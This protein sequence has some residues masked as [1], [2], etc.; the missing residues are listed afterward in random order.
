MCQVRYRASDATCPCVLCDLRVCVVA[1]SA[2]RPCAALCSRRS[3][4]FFG[5]FLLRWSC[6]SQPSRVAGRSCGWRC[7]VRLVRDPLSL[8]GAG[9]CA[10]EKLPRPIVSSAVAPDVDVS[11][12]VLFNICTSALMRHH[13]TESFHTSSVDYCLVGLLRCIRYLR[14]CDPSPSA[15]PDAV[16]LLHF[17]FR[18]CLFSLHVPEGAASG[19]TAGASTPASSATAGPAAPGGAAPASSATD[20]TGTATPDHMSSPARSAT[21]APGV[22]PRAMLDTPAPGTGSFTAAN[23]SGGELVAAA[24][25]NGADAGTDSSLMGSLCK[26][27]TS[28]VAA[29]AL[30]LELSR[31]SRELALAHLK[32]VHHHETDTEYDRRAWSY[33]P[34]AVRHDTMR[35]AAVLRWWLVVGCCVLLASWHAEGVVV[36]VV[37]LVV[38][39]RNMR[40]GSQRA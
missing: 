34:A 3:P 36:V 26:T 7:F 8:R 33:D 28:R 39:G 27:G 6:L 9:A 21:D 19:D 38:L 29:F 40:C 13:S 14:R 12:A 35:L 30:L 17:T 32:L 31:G 4:E 24:G 10:D 15:T 18:R 5:V 20:S 37:V 25:N 16:Q 1:S 23:M 22:P 11:R 2:C